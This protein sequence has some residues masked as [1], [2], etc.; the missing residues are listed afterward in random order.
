MTFLIDSSVW[1]ALFL[2]FDT[3]HTKAVRVFPTLTGTTYA[4]YCVI[5]EVATILAYKHSKTQADSFLKYLEDNSGVV[6]LDDN[7]EDE[8]AFYKSFNHKMSFTDASLIFLSKKLNAEL[9]TFDQQLTRIAKMSS[10]K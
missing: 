1:I 9:V 5:G 3:Q 7:A 6:L 4:P 2:D 10:H 8:I